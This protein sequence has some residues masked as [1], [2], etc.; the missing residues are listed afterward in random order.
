VTVAVEVEAEIARLYH[1]EHWKVG[2]IAAQVGVHEDVVRRVL[3]LLKPRS[4]PERRERAPLPV[5]PFIDFINETLQKYPRLRST[6]LWDM[7][8]ERG[9]SGSERS[10]R[11]FVA[12][13]RP[14]PQREAFL[15]LDP[16]CGE[17]AQ[18]DWA[19]VG[20]IPVPGGGS[21]SLWLF[22][23]VL[24]WSRATWGEFCF[25]T[26]V[27]SLLRSLVRAADHFG[28]VTRQWLFD[29]PKI[30]V[31]ERHGD[32]ARFHP[33]LLDLSS[34][35]HVQLRLCGPYRGNEKGRVERRIRF[36]RDR[37]LAGRDIYDI[38]QGN[39]ELLIFLQQIAHQRMHPNFPQRQVEEC[40]VEEKQR[41]L[42]L[43]DP[44]PQTDL[45]EPVLVDKTAFAH[46]DTNLYSVPPNHVERTLTLVAD[47]RSVRVL[48][49]ASVVAHHPR[50]WG[51]RQK[52]E[53]PDH[54][55]EIL[56]RKRGAAP[57]AGRDRLRAVAPQ[58]DILFERWVTAGRNVGS[59]TA[60]TSKLLDLYAADVFEKAVAEVI[61]R[62]THDPGEV[63]VLCEKHRRA[64][65]RPV[66]IDIRLR[67]HIPDRDV[68]PHDLGGYDAKR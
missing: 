54:R 44:M 52:I 42:P 50:S 65:E 9:F 61:L 31:L 64:A 63:G 15:R 58:I 30:V 62:G 10:L 57:S 29:N 19:H 25:D 34:A 2:T 23:M 26:T 40:L 60:Q 16:L 35:L 7:L 36:L 37:F 38:E 12:T 11:R 48:D 28:G 67:D 22:L 14:A 46:F 55:A 21:R 20:H 24:S 59:M 43:P 56:R 47:D 27:H 17:Q 33:L 45:V 5:A 1:A 41:L 13:V 32:A 18:I 51:H 39:R 4:R 53:H 6:R 68:I 8:K 3:G 66:P 49:G